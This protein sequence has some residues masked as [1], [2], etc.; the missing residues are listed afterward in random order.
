M[1]LLDIHTHLV[2]YGEASGYP[3]G[4]AVDELIAWMDESGVAQ[5]VILPLE[6]PECDTEYAPSAQAWELCGEFPDRL[7]PFVGA[8]PRQQQVLEKVRH[9][10]GRGAKGY[11]EHKCG[12]A[13]DDE[14][15]MAVYRLCGE[16]RLPVLFHMDPGLNSDEA[17]L[18]GLERALR[19]APET[20]FIA[21]GPGW[22]TAISGD[23]DRAG[24]YPSGAISPGG[25]ADRLLSEC[26]N[27]Y[28][29]ISA[30]SGNNALTRDPGFTE[31]FL[32]RHWRKLLFGSD[33]F[34]VGQRVPQ[35]EWLRTYPMPDEWREAIGWGNARRLLGLAG[36]S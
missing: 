5:A 6:S 18:P 24:G 3:R 23:D 27:L 9:Y 30:G 12:L 10:H 17:G 21:H 2:P 22:W 32:A 26:P 35:V 34:L 7:I 4:I 8:D 33:Y 11:G 20:D 36:E 14:R 25:A 19:E 29:E 16:V 28:A 15:S 31:G 13:I 1:N